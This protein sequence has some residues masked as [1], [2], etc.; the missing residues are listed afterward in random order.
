MVLICWNTVGRKELWNSGKKISCS[1]RC[2]RCAFLPSYLFKA[3]KVSQ[4]TGFTFH[5]DEFSIRELW[6]AQALQVEVF[7]ALSLTR[8]QRV[9]R[10]FTDLQYSKEQCISDVSRRQNHLEGL[11]PIVSDTAGGGGG[12]GK[13]RGRGQEFAFTASIRTTLIL[14]VLGPHC[15]S[16]WTR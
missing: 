8:N 2:R 12:G 14:L 10:A 5:A 4:L 3:T 15:E 1:E 11:S 7:V 16:H 13:R 9:T 6:R